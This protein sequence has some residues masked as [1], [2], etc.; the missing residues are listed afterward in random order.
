MDDQ[1]TGGTPSD[2]PRAAPPPPWPPAPGGPRLVPWPPVPVTSPQDGLATA[3]LVFGIIGVLTALIILGGLLGVVGIVLGIVALGRRR[4]G[5]RKGMAVGGIVT[6]SIAV[7]I[8][9]GMIVVIALFGDDI[10]DYSD[11]MDRARTPVET[12]A[13]SDHFRPD[14]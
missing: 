11:C 10:A 12:R 5:A 3:S 6:G 14:R 7:L 8:T 1:P 4:E 13:C 9:I 2:E